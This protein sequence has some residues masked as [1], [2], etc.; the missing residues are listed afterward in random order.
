[1]IVEGGG[2]ACVGRAEFVV[3]EPD[4]SVKRRMPMYQARRAERTVMLRL[5]RQLLRFSRV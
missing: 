3:S 4:L 2:G 5:G 1:M